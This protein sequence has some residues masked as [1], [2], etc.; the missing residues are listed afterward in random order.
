MLIRNISGAMKKKYLY[1]LFLQ[2]HF[3]P[4]SLSL[5]FQGPLYCE[6][7]YA[8]YWHRG[9]LNS[10]HFYNFFLLIAVLIGWFSQFYLPYHFSITLIPCRVCVC[11]CVCVCVIYIFQN[12]SYCIQFCWFFLIFSFSVDVSHWISPF[13]FWVWWT[14]FD[15]FFELF[16]RV[17]TYLKTI[18]LGFVLGFY[19]ALLF[20]TYS[21][22]SSLCL[23]FDFYFYELGK[24]STSPCLSRVFLCGCI[25]VS[26]AHNWWLWQVDSS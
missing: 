23:T 4:L 21:F 3:L 2:I 5:I 9:P 13:I 8:W 16:I 11:V 17:N 25:L 12:F 1:T 7:Y 19:F 26:T 14:S 10:P 18:S 20:G 6:S 22:V 24:T 15:H